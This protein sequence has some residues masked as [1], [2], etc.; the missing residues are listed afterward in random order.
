MHQTQAF[1]N[2][3][4]P[5]L[6]EIADQIAL[7]EDIS[8]QRRADLR[9]A[10]AT[11]AHVVGREA[12]SLPA[13][14]TLLRKLLEQAKPARFQVKKARWAN[15]R[16]LLRAALELGGVK[17]TPAAYL[18]P[19]GPDWQ[20]LYQQLPERPHRVCLSRLMRFCTAL[21]IGPSQVTAEH[22]EQ[23]HAA[24]E[25]EDVLRNP[26]AVHRDACRFWNLSAQHCPD[27][28]ALRVPV[29]DYRV[30][31]SLPW[32]VFPASLKQDFDAMLA[33]ALDPFE[34]SDQK[35]IKP[36]SARQR[37]YVVQQ[38]ASALVLRGRP[39]ESIRSLADLVEVTAVKECLRFY[40]D[41]FGPENNKQIRQTLIVLTS[42]ARRWVKV[43]SAEL[44]R[45]YAIKK[46]TAP[47]LTGMTE[48]NKETVRQFQDLELV[49]R[50]LALPE[51]LFRDE[52]SKPPSL[53]SALRLQIALAIEILTVAPMRLK[54]LAN[55]DLDQHL[56]RIGNQAVHIYLPGGQVKNGMSLELPLPARTQGLLTSYV[57]SYRPLQIQ[58]QHRFLFPGRGYKSK[59][60]TAL[61]TQITAMLKAELGIAMTAHQFRHV[62]G[63]LFLLQNPGAYEVVRRL[64][65]HKDIQTT[66][67]FYTDLDLPQAARQYDATLDRLREAVP[68]P[69][70]RRK[71]RV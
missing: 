15:V 53:R 20:V 50:Y 52:A 34:N 25:S 39:P 70:T 22:F 13:H 21:N 32:D 7:R 19:I 14:P 71:Q 40:R 18:V 17:A 5:S 62:A 59:Q 38:A 43:S 63:Y 16:S 47:R 45:L 55:L 30:R 6:A 54:N 69:R 44:A 65:G 58:E 3:D 2:P 4:W 29:P 36:I 28:P 31:Y 66:I 61:G 42:I 24:L 49:Q 64:L 41:R 23:F 35:K 26:R 56:K 27:W 10:I 68:Q 1:S 12:A 8:P 33:E 48:K 37:L 57:K 9:A 67:D 46:A 51:R 60:S 11:A